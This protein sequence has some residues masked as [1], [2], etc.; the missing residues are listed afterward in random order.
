MCRSPVKLA[1][2]GWFEARTGEPPVL[3]LDEMLAEL[4]VDRRVELLSRVVGTQQA[5][6]TTTDLEMFEPTFF[7]GALIWR[8]TAGELAPDGSDRRLG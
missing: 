7:K 2:L 4:D 3:L 1:E 6:V 5:I 8:I